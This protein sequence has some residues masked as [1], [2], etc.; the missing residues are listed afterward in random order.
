M[1]LLKLFTLQYL[2]LSLCCLDLCEN[3]YN[4]EENGLPITAAGSSDD[5][6]N[7]RGTLQSVEEQVCRSSG[8]STSGSSDTSASSDSAS[9][10]SSEDRHPPAANVCDLP[11]ASHSREPTEDRLLSRRLNSQ[12][13][14]E[15]QGSVSSLKGR[16]RKRPHS[17]ASGSPDHEDSNSP[18]RLYADGMDDSG[19]PGG[20]GKAGRNSHQRL[21]EIQASL[22]KDLASPVTGRMAAA[23]VSAGPFD[24]C[25]EDQLGKVKEVVRMSDSA[26]DD[27]GGD[28]D[29]DDDE[30]NVK[31]VT[32]VSGSASSAVSTDDEE[33]YESADETFSAIAQRKSSRMRAARRRSVKN[34]EDGSNI[35]DQSSD[36]QSSHKYPSRHRNPSRKARHIAALKQAAL[37]V[38]TDDNDIGDISMGSDSSSDDGYVPGNAESVKRKR[39]HGSVS[40]CSSNSSIPS[41]HPRRCKNAVPIDLGA[42]SSASE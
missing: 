14:I 21:Q 24:E 1:I 20:L 18:K 16:G 5:I 32:D 31:M 13:S 28:D 29:D 22:D 34:T 8:S 11:D 12:V 7:R 37:E 19:D 23:A 15:S 42:Q 33:S 2:A 30:F 17:V 36:E 40:A 27:N 4:G 26:E 39:Q 41:R 10:S 3:N 9:S 38:G 25:L 6:G 35:S